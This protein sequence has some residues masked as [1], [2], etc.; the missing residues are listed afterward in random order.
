MFGT[1]LCA[2]MYGA[3]M[4]TDQEKS[5]PLFHT[6]SSGKDSEGGLLAQVQ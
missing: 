2:V 3:R 5:D 1:W 4:E 6:N